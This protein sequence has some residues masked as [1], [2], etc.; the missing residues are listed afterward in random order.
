MRTLSTTST[1]RLSPWIPLK[2]ER[3]IR[4]HLEK[5]YWDI[6]VIDEAH[7]VAI[8][9]TRSDRAKLGEK[10]AHRSDTMILASATPHDGRAES[11][12]S[13]MNM[14][15]PTAIANPKQYVREDIEGLYLRRFRNQV[16]A[17]MGQSM[18]DRATFKFSAAA[19]AAEEGA[20]AMLA[21]TSFASFDKGNRN[22]QLLFRTVLEKALFSSPAACRK[23]IEQ[24]RKTLAS[25]T[26]PEAAQ[27]RD[28][29]S[30]L[31]AAV[32]AVTPGQF[33][34]YQNLLSSSRPGGK[35]STGTRNART[36]AW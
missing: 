35:T 28:T 29:L 27:D 12:A 21:A 10:L 34:R 9:G 7:N 18:L 8:R 11:F 2:Q 33:S 22:G 30:S 3:D 23:T 20:Y 19:S 15:N 5:S 14:L 17:Q 1:R 26:T 13:L 4:V 32:D 24:R 25:K 31:A 6:I 16:Q 36:T